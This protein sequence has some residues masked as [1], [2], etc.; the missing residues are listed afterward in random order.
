MW[1]LHGFAPMSKREPRDIQS[2][3]KRISLELSQGQRSFSRHNSGPLPALSL[4]SCGPFWLHK[5][6]E[7]SRVG[8]K[9][10]AARKKA[11]LEQILRGHAPPNA[12][13]NRV[14]T[15]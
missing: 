3:C 8:A 4:D 7:C 11:N 2:A 14:R 12:V 6:M 15:S 13:R 1:D 10:R 9:K 5:E